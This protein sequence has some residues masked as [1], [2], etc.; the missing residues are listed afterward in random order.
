MRLI[1]KA[2]V[3]MLVWA[4]QVP[5]GVAYV[6]PP[7]QLLDLMLSNCGT[8]SRLQVKQR[9]S[10]FPEQG[11][12]A[13][14]SETLSFVFPDRFHAEII[15]G[16]EQRLL[17][18]AKEGVLR[19]MG[20]AA[21][22]SEDR[23]DLYKDLILYRQRNL[24]IQR[25]ER[26][27]VNTAVASLGRFQ[28][29][30][31][32]VLGAAYPNEAAVQVWLD[33]QSFRPLRWIIDPGVEVRY[34]NWKRFQGL[35]YPERIEILRQG[36]LAAAVDADQVNVDAPLAPGLFDVQGLR[37]RYAPAAATGK[38]LGPGQKP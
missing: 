30:P 2:M 10:V 13:V 32:F 19:V 15:S 4:W 23:L 37:R 11:E 18:V 12:P 31:V 28:D 24:L 7:P 3:M 35:W 9:L 36:R 8:A 17:V 6:P 34:L 21:V 26:L 38:P 27:G 25:L 1:C 20:G 14:Y 22:D 29:Q 5:A 33:K 16:P